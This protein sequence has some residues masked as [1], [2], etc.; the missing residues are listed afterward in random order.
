MTTPAWARPVVEFRHPSW[1][2]DGVFAL[3]ERQGVEKF[4][5]A[6][7]DLMDTVRARIDEIPSDS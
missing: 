5:T 6:W 1:F 4:V 2:D 3:L 7:D